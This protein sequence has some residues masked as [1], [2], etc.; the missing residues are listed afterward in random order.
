MTKNLTTKLAILSLAGGLMGAA[1]IAAGP[2]ENAVVA[3]GV[4][5]MVDVKVGDNAPDFTLTDTAGAKHTLSEYT[6]QGKIVVLEWFNPGC[7]FVI[8]NHE[9]FTTMIDTYAEFKDKDV[10]WLAINSGA[11]GKQGYGKELNAKMKDEW[12][13]EYPILLDETGATGKAFGAKTTPHMFIV[14]RDGTVAYRGAIDNA[15][16]PN[17]Q[18]DVNY[19]KDALN[20]LIA[21]ETVAKADTKSY[22]CSVK[23]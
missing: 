11:A 14:G 16:S 9:T 3:A 21:G 13:I 17:K 8:K 15:P 22:G 5:G 12:K 23:Y 2:V 7:P 10:V 18:G 19:V 1:T 4:V 6:K 20:S